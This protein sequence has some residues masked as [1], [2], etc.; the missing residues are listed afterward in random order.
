MFG[1]DALADSAVV[2]K[3]GIKTRPI[4]QWEVKRELLKRIKK[5]FDEL[6][7][8]IPFPQRTVWTRQEQG[9]GEDR[10]N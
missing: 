8:E 6:G 5:R 3:F 4:K 2:I 10:G 9:R 7:I 1:V